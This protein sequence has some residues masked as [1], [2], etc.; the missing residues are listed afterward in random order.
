MARTGGDRREG[1]L[2]IDGCLVKGASGHRDGEKRKQEFG[3]HSRSRRAS[4]APSTRRLHF[5]N[6]WEYCLIEME[7]LQS[8]VDVLDES[9]G[10]QHM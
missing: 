1:D 4:F 3:G 5:E 8:D 6:E 9:G 7:P 2:G 10:Q